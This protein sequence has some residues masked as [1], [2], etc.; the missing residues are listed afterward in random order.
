MSNDGSFIAVPFV[1]MIAVLALVMVT[2]DDEGPDMSATI[3]ATNEW[4]YALE[5]AIVDTHAW[6]LSNST[7]GFTYYNVS[8]GHTLKVHVECHKD[9]GNWSRY[10]VY[11]RT[12]HTQSWYA[13]KIHPRPGERYEVHMEVSEW[14]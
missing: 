10:L 7:H 2:D 14:A 9:Y 12:D 8:A 11:W 5:V 13:E 3:V 1:V 4:D 6:K